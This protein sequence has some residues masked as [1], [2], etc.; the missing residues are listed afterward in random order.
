MV[1]NLGKIRNQ[2]LGDKALSLKNLVM[3]SI[4]LAKDWYIAAK[5][6]FITI[7]IITQPF[8]HYTTQKHVIFTVEKMERVSY[9]ESSRYLIFTKNE[10]FENKDSIAFFKFNSSDIY[11]QMNEG[12]TYRAKVAGARIPFFSRHRNIIEIQKE[13]K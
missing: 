9:G 7:S 2:N 8:F 6:A 12:E 10:T 11:N 3:K 5:V 4:Y 1:F 13:S